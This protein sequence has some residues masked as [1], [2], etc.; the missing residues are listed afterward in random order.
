ME[1]NDKMGTPKSE[2][3]NYNIYKKSK[4][5]KEDKI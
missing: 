2:N 4:S 1:M 5:Y 3:I